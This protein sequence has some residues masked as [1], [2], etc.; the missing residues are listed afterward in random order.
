[1]EGLIIGALLLFGG[2]LF[3]YFSSDLPHI[4]G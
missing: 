3:W 2:G 1:M 4:V